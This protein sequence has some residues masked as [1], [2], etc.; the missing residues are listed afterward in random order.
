MRAVHFTRFDHQ[1]KGQKLI[2]I[3][4]STPAAELLPPS[5]LRNSCSEQAGSSGGAFRRVSSILVFISGGIMRGRFAGIARNAN[6]CSTGNA[7]HRRFSNLSVIDVDIV[8]W[9]P[10]RFPPGSKQRPKFTLGSKS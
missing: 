9:P 8:A 7:T 2:S 3:S 5:T 6:T 10:H 4:E 1:V